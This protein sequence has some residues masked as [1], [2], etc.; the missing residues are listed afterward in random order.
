M[1]DSVARSVG[2]PARG[3]PGP[4]HLAI[5]VH[6]VGPGGVTTD[7]Q[8]IPVRQ[9]LSAALVVGKLM[10]DDLCSPV[11]ARILLDHILVA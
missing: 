10:L 9:P 2:D 3:F 6:L 8:R 4:H 7:D 1:L 5:L 11:G